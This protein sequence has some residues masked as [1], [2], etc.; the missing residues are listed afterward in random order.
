VA[1][2]FSILPKVGL[3]EQQIPSSLLENFSKKMA[4]AGAWV[5]IN[6]K[7]RCPT[8]AVAHRLATDGVRIVAGSDSHS[9]MQ[10]GRYGHVWRVGG[11]LLGNPQ[12]A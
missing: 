8:R 7:W 12:A 11:D 1:H 2:L 4:A 9:S 3:G 10:L 5:E 6:E